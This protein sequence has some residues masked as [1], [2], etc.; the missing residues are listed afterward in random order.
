VSGADNSDGA[1]WA[2][3]CAGDEHAFGALFVRH[4]D[5]VY[6]FCFR[7]LG[8]YAAAE[9][10]VQVVFMDTWRKR[11]SVTVEES[12]LP[13][14]YGV[15]SNV[16]RNASRATRRYA[17]LL[18]AAP[19]EDEVADHADEVA[20]RLDDERQMQAVL[21]AFRKLPQREQEALALCD[22]QDLSH[23]EAAAVLGVPVGTV[24]SRITRGRKRLRAALGVSEPNGVEP[25]GSTSEGV[26]GESS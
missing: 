7:R 25:G 20:D 21:A 12:L 1:L 19:H 2:R 16:V 22:W 17:G 18:L 3:A 5:A 9:D 10:A 8:S 13:F 6:A 26:R 4:V 24:K 14:L 11:D 15:A 23:S